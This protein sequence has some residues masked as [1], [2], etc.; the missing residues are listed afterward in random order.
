MKIL[1]G[2]HAG[3]TGRAHQYANDWLTADLDDGTRN[4]TLKP[5]MVQLEDDED[6]AKFSTTDPNIVGQFWREW[7]LN[8]DGTFTDLRRERRASRAGVR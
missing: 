1:R 6:W 8:G 5:S 2:K 4:V 3:K 7:R